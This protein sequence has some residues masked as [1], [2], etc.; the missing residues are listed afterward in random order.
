MPCPLSR[1]PKGCDAS[2]A[3]WISTLRVWETDTGHERYRFSQAP[4]PV[5]FSPFGGVFEI[6]AAFSP[7]GKYLAVASEMSTH[8]DLR[9]TAT[10]KMGRSIH[11]SGV[12]INFAFSPAGEM[13]AVA[14]ESAL[15]T[16]GK[17]T[18]WNTTTAK[19]DGGTLPGSGKIVFSRDG[20][21][22][23]V[24]GEKTI[25]VWELASGKS[26]CTFRL[27]PAETDVPEAA[28]V[29]T[30]TGA[31]LVAVL[32]AHDEA[33]FW[34]DNRLE[35]WDVIDGKRLRRL[36]VPGN[37]FVKAAFAPDGSYLATGMADTSVLLWQLSIL[38]GE[39]ERRRILDSEAL[40]KLWKDLAAA[41]AKRAYQ[42]L[43]ALA[44]LPDQAV[45]FLDPSAPRRCG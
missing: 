42:A 9:D 15:S 27:P 7:N 31:L 28:A 6:L 33:P 19:A 39:L 8:I 1:W 12:V 36:K 41:D 26:V 17:I 34:A 24:C 32:V 5:P 44:A 40:T 21:L 38:A 37:Q 22:L 43:R 25:R 13:M 18:F 10:G 35:L 29:F 23:A 4:I 20:R 30:P 45:P 2:Q 3:H 16:E 11:P 14:T